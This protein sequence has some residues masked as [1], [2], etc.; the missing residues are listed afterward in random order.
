MLEAI[1][2]LGVEKRWVF[3]LVLGIVTVT[4]VGTMGWMGMSGPSGAYAAKVNG[5][6]VLLADFQ[7][8]YRDTYRNYERMLGDKFDPELIKSLN[9]PMQVVM[10]LVDRKLWLSLGH[11]LGLAATDDEVRNALLAIQ[12][13]Q[14]NG[15]FNSRRYQD[16]LSRIDSSPEAF[17]N[18]LRDDLVIEKARRIVGSAVRLTAADLKD[19]PAPEEGASPEEAERQRADGRE[20]LL[21]RKRAQLLAAYTAELRHQAKIRIFRENFEALGV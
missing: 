14:T 9:L 8:Q 1:R 21:S 4:F 18:D 5:E 20:G 3:G 10:A 2:R 16:V 15:R 13:F 12:A 11:D 19:L 7:R 17:E 6:V